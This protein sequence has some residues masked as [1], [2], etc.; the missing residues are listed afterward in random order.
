MSSQT[1]TQT[2]QLPRATRRSTSPTESLDDQ[3]RGYRR[4]QRARHLV[5]QRIR[6]MTSR[7][8]RTSLE[9]YLD[10]DQE[11]TLSR[12]RRANLVP[13]EVLYTY[14]T[15]EPL[16]RVYQHYEEV[17]QHVVDTQLDLRFIEEESYQILQREGMQHIH[18]GMMMVR[19]QVTHRVDS[20]IQ[21]M[22]VF[23]DTRWSDDRQILSAMT[24]DL[25]RGT[26]MVYAIP[27][28]LTSIHDF[29][30][31]IQVSIVTRGYGF[32]WTGGESNM[33]ITRS[34]IGRITNTSQANFN[35]NIEGVTDY[36]VSQGVRALPGEA[37]PQVNREESWALRPSRILPPLFTPT[38]MISRQSGTGNIS[39]RFLDHKET[40]EP[41][42]E[43]EEGGRPET[44]YGLVCQFGEVWDTLGEPPGKFDYMVK[45]SPPD[46]AYHD[47]QIT[48][49]GWDDED[50]K[51]DQNPGAF[52]SIAEGES[53]GSEEEMLYPQKR[54]ASTTLNNDLVQQWLD[55]L[56]EQ[57]SQEPSYDTSDDEGEIQAFT[58]N[59]DYPKMREE[60]IQKMEE[61]E[62]AY[63]GTSGGVKE[64]FIPPNQQTGPVKY[65]PAESSAGFFKEPVW[66]GQQRPENFGKALAP[67]QL[68]SAY[69]T[70][71]ALFVLPPEI[72]SHA[73]A[74]TTWETV[75]LNLLRQLTF[76]SL[77]DKVDYIENLLGPREKETWITWRM[78]YATEYSTIVT[79]ADEPRNV[80]SAIKRIL[81]FSDP[82]TGNLHAQNRAYAD[83]E[84]LQC[85]DMASVMAFLFAYYQ[86]AAQSGRMWD[87]PELSEKLFR[88]LPPEIGP[89]IQKEYTEKYPGMTVGVLARIHFISEYLQN[90][91]KQADLQRKLKNLNFCRTVPIP[92]YYNTGSGKRK[93]GIRKAKNFKGKPHNTHVKVIK[94]KTKQT[95]AAEGRKCKCFLC[96]VEGHFARECPKKHVKPERAAFF[97]GLDLDKNWDLVS[98]P[99]K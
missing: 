98:V 12:R 1:R 65:L 87:G 20:G 60:I 22:I 69:Q 89:T 48:P 32:G 67:W 24:M 27:N 31:H 16:N 94:N 78:A 58:G 50:D 17:R 91:C 7:T 40:P 92:G 71:G 38:R 99:V 86:L 28:L 33:L 75:T 64:E 95:A 51:G 46:W 63:P 88:K 84:R 90:L 25:S 29:H 36:L 82:F 23:R 53:S 56:G 61:L 73:D 6:R 97:S 74:I 96:G 93:Y 76:E 54:Q 9:Q 79:A 45:Y 81:G 3:I 8:F 72:A 62:Y 44:H 35:Y 77:Q 2:E 4:W 34:L 59:L 5:N 70:Q 66:Q 15:H 80:T 47:T 11:L 57:Q 19:L 52:V 85:P 68:P 49:T 55:Q 13:A 26:Q 30:N 41:L 83:L 14:N 43:E 37:W 10:P 18:I 21:A 39:I 42:P